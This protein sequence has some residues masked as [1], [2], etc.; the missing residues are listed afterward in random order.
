[1]T[2]ALNK[3]ALQEAFQNAA[4]AGKNTLREFDKVWAAI[5][6]GEF[7]LP[8]TRQA[9]PQPVSEVHVVLTPSADPDSPTEVFVE[10]ED[11][12]GHGIGGFRTYTEG[13]IGN[14]VHQYRH[15]VIPQF[16]EKDGE[17][18]IQEAGEELAHYVAEEALEEAAIVKDW[19]LIVDYVG[20]DTG[21]EGF[22]RQTG[23]TYASNPTG[24]M[25]AALGMMSIVRHRLLQVDADDESYGQA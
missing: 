4:Q 11:A 17:F 16:I 24:S 21:G 2:N 7:D 6:R 9:P 3:T 20:E 13:D 1:M 19:L 25:S 22:I 15:I 5:N 14:G 18:D 8:T 23:T 12:E 10:T